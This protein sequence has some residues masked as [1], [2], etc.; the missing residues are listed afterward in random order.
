[1]GLSQGRGD[2][3]DRGELGEGEEKRKDGPI[4]S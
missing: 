4:M 3:G 1:M 2:R